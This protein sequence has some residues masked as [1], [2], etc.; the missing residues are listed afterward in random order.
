M[1]DIAKYKV[2][3]STKK[4]RP[5]ETAESLESGSFVDEVWD[6]DVLVVVESAV[7]LLQEK[8]YMF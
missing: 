7:S 4:L 3:K 8:K 6:E 1:L 5:T 2:V